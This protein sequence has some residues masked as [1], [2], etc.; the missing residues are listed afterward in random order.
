MT[1]Q[2]KGLITFK[3]KYG[4][5]EELALSH[6]LGYLVV[7]VVIMMMIDAFVTGSVR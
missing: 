4:N 3:I 7:R 5:F 6:Y 1:E 2:A